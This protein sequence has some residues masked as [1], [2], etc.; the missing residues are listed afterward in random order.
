MGPIGIWAWWCQGNIVWR[1]VSL[2]HLFSLIPVSS[3][4]KETIQK[5]PRRFDVLG[6]NILLRRDHLTNAITDLP[7]LEYYQS[8]QPMG[9]HRQT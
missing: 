8:L 1:P 6:G 9:E 4:G 5:R 2:D 3:D 7:P